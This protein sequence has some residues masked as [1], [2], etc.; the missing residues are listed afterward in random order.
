MYTSDGIYTSL[1]FYLKYDNLYLITYRFSDTIDLSTA[2]PVV[3][4]H[5]PY[6]FILIKIA[7]EWA[8]T[9]DGNLPSTRDEKKV[10][11]VQY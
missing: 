9:H 5:T 4:K 8:K 6:V 7:D 1:L 11:K 2:D 3:H 10:F